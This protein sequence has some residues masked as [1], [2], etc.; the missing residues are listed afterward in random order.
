MTAFALG[1]DAGGSIRT[2]AAL[3]GLYG[4]R[5]TNGRIARAFGFPPLMVDFQAIGLL[6]RSLADL[7]LLYEYAAGPDDRDPVSLLVP[8][9]SVEGRPVRAGWVVDLRGFLIEPEIAERVET[10]AKALTAAGVEVAKVEPPCDLGALRDVQAVLRG[11]GVRAGIAAS[12]DPAGPLSPP[13]QAVVDAP[14]DATAADFAAAMRALTAFRRE[15]SVAMSAYD[16]LLLPTTPTWAWSAASPRPDTI[17]GQPVGS[18][19]GVLYRMGQRGR[20]PRAQR[21][22]RAGGQRPPDRGAAGRS[23]RRRPDRARPR[24]ARRD[25]D[26]AGVA[27]QPYARR[28]GAGGCVVTRRLHFSAAVLMLKCADLCLWN[29]PVDRPGVNLMLRRGGGCFTLV[30][31]T[32]PALTHADHLRR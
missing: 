6:T 17:A 22:G 7:R 25:A 13:V 24:G 12:P 8:N 9:R 4:L 16:A 31:G 26:A 27:D 19:G 14:F 28:R 2:P 30:N 18:A 10:A 29:G 3:T 23:R 11:A 32:K 5:P 20:L 21:P 1:T 15:V